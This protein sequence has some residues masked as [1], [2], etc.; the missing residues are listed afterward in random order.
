VGIVGVIQGA[1]IEELIR[2]LERRGVSLFHACQYAD[3]CAY[4]ALGGIP[5]RALLEGRGQP[6]TPF[7][8]DTH[9]RRN[10][11][12]NKVF[13]NLAD[14][15]EWFA[16]GKSWVPNPYGPIAIQIRPAAL[17]EAAD[18]AVCYRSAGAADFDR[19]REA[20]PQLE[21]IEG[22]FRYPLESGFPYSIY[23]KSIPE[24][25]A[26]RPG[27]KLPEVSCTVIS[28]SLPLSQ[29]IVVWTDPYVLGGRSLRDW[30]RA[31]MDDAGVD[32][33]LWA[34]NCCGKRRALY[35]ELLWRV[36]AG[37]DSLRL[38]AAD[39]AAGPEL[40]VWATTALEQ[41]LDYQFRRYAHYLRAGTIGPLAGSNDRPARPAQASR[42]LDF[43]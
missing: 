11:A 43:A 5:S 21:E 38:L 1:Q 42:Q 22:L 14:F 20:I 7:E 33:R 9:D 19:E 10:G 12:W 6:F 29:A 16:R 35:G 24:L 28:G 15:G 18:V 27:A 25:Q 32:I 4:L 2:L 30:V 40:R 17:L 3:F 37:C 23:L 36:M 13:V 26:L 39:Y 31:A 8:S 34:R 41:G